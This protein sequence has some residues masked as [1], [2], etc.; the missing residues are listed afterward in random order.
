MKFLLAFLAL[1]IISGNSFAQSNENEK[2]KGNSSFFAEGGGPGIM[3][4]LNIDKRFNSSRFG[5]G[6]RA[7]L[8]FVTGWQYNDQT[9]FDLSSAIT[10]PVQLNYVFGKENSPHS[11]EAGGGVTYVS[12]KFDIMEFYDEKQT[13]VFGTVSFMYRRQPKDGGF[14]WRAGFSPLIGKDLIQLFGGVSIGYNF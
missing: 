6:A 12:K 2:P 13:Q 10:V 7:G 1:I 5:L 9:Y 3:F 11:L 8:G 4:S 14:S